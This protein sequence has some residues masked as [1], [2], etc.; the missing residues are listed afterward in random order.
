MFNFMLE[1]GQRNLIY[2]ISGIGKT[3]STLLFCHL[4]SMIADFRVKENTN[5]VEPFVD[6]AQ[7]VQIPKIIY[8]DIE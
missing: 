3:I 1:N 8:L 6:L 4:S 2:G 5:A 7:F